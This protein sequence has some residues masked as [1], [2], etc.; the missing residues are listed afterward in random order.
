MQSAAYS[1]CILCHIP[2]VLL[3]SVLSSGLASCERWEVL[4]NEWGLSLWGLGH[5]WPR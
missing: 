5:M 1:S 4:C 2:V 3:L